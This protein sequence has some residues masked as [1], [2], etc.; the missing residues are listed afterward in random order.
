MGVETPTPIINE[1]SLRLN[2]TNEG[3]VAGD[4]RFLKNIIGLWLVQECRRHWEKSGQEYSY[5]E[6]TEMA[7]T[8]QPFKAIID[9]ND[10]TF[11]APAKCPTRSPNSVPAPT[12]GCLRTRVRSSAPAWS[13]RARLIA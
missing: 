8:A 2:Y 10:K 1:K 11:L 13:A 7:A 5:T 12:R 9:P 4:F 3:G 6:L